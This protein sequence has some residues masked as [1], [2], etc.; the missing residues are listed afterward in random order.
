MNP[1]QE[2]GGVENNSGMKVKV[3]GDNSFDFKFK[4]KKNR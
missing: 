3:L 4:I 1:R 2:F